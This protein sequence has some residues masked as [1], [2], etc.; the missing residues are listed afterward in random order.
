MLAFLSLTE[1]IKKSS[2]EKKFTVVSN[3]ELTAIL[4][5]K[6]SHYKNI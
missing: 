6:R 2:N 5:K 4:G 3:F 1:K